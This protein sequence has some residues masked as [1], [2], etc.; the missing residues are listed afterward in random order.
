[1]TYLRNA[2]NR[3][4]AIERIGAAALCVP[5]TMLASTPALAAVPQAR[6]STRYRRRNSRTTST[7]FKLSWIAVPQIQR[8]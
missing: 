4:Q 7:P 3:R 2:M 6:I 5:A 8:S 1:M